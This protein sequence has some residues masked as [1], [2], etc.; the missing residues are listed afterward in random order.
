M[1]WSDS[2]TGSMNMS[3]SKLQEIVKDRDLACCS[4]WGCKESDATK[5]LNKVSLPPIVFFPRFHN[6]NLLKQRYKLLQGATYEAHTIKYHTALKKG[7]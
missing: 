1:R 7:I 4:P 2:I 5:Q 6:K 3:L